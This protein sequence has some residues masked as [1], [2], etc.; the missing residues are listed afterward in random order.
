MR[1]AAFAQKVGLELKP[2]SIA[3]AEVYNRE[4]D[5]TARVEGSRLLANPNVQRVIGDLREQFKED[6]VKAYEILCNMMVDKSVPSAVRKQIASEIMDRAG[7]GATQKI[8][9][10][11][12]TTFQGITDLSKEELRDMLK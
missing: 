7:Y 4:P 9:Q 1:Q 6:S 5:A 2:A 11:N 3:Y 8:E 12:E 10:K